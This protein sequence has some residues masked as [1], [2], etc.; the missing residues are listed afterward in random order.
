MEGVEDTSSNTVLPTGGTQIFENSSPSG[1][2]SEQPCGTAASIHANSDKGKAKELVSNINNQDLTKSDTGTTQKE[3]QTRL[4]W[5]V[6]TSKKTFPVLFPYENVPGASLV[7]K[8][9]AVFDLIGGI[10][11]YLNLDLTS[12]NGAKYFRCTYANKLAAE[13]ACKNAFPNQDNIKFR[14]GEEVKS[15]SASAAGFS[16]KIHD[17]PLDFDKNLFSKFLNKI[18]KVV[19]LK[20]HVRG[21]YYICHVTFELASTASKFT[22]WCVNFGKNSFCCYPASLSKEEFDHHRK[23]GLKLTNL[24]PSTTPYDLFEII[25]K[26]GGRTC[27]I[28]KKQDANSYSKERF[29]YVQFNSEDDK[30]RAKSTAFQFKNKGLQWADTNT[31]TCFVCGSS[32]HLIRNCKEA[33]RS[34]NLAERNNRFARIYSQYGAKPPTPKHVRPFLQS[35]ELDWNLPS[36]DPQAQYLRRRSASRS[37]SVSNRSR[38]RRTPSSNNRKVFSYAEA[39]ASQVLP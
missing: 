9:S 38:P 24:P 5:T 10:I 19:S 1:F 12:I 7:E 31:R 32:L 22:D 27:F 13:E 17:I 28:P 30:E 37:I 4:A 3:K 36:D 23:Y 39:A 33:R 6:V 25:S 29:A 15:A 21:L 11:G 8:K 35:D 14:M 2:T 20:Y 26:V 16:L 18:D 34:A